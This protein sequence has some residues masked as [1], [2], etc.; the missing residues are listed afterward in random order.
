MTTT[1]NTSCLENTMVCQQGE[2]LCMHVFS[3]NNNYNA[4]RASRSK[5][6]GFLWTTLIE[7]AV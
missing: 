5:F 4:F 2:G 1:L 3:S 7:L 6:D